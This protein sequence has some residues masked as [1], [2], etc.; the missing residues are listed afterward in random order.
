MNPALRDEILAIL[1][2]ANDMTL[3]TVRSDGYPQAT[4]VSY[5][6]SGL[7]LYF[8]CASDSQKARNLA[9]NSKVSL[10]INLPYSN[11]G[12]IRGLSVGGRAELITDPR[13]AEQA[14][15][16]MVRKFPEAIAEYASEELAGVSLFR[17]V[18]EVISVLDYRKGFGHTDIVHD[19]GDLA[20]GPDVVE[21]ADEES[22]PASDPPAWT[23]TTA[24]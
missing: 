11:W 22:F 2:E 15:A 4:T 9:R 23:R 17:V 19:I 14:G 6:N 12:D 10:T 7:I 16:V 13:E 1:K 24:R 8:G 18:P 3:A 21:E 5:A 20:A